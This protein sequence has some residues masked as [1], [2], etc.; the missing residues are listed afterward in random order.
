MMETDL[1]EIEEQA[2]EHNA[3]MRLKCCT[4]GIYPNRDTK[5]GGRWIGDHFYCMRHAALVNGAAARL[6]AL[7]VTL[8][9]GEPMAE[10]ILG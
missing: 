10:Q 5:R 3:A 4:C 7:W 1:L 6:S 9:G 8:Q 2:Q